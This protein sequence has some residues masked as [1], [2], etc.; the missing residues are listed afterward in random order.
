M[1]DVGSNLARDLIVLVQGEG[2]LI[3]VWMVSFRLA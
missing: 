2:D 1:R 3:L